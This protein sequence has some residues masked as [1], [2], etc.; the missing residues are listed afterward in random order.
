MILWTYSRWLPRNALADA[1]FGLSSR[2][3]QRPTGFI[4]KHAA[5]SPLSS[6][7]RAELSGLKEMTYLWE[8]ASLAQD[9]RQLQALRDTSGTV[10]RGSCRDVAQL[11]RNRAG[12]LC[13]SVRKKCEAVDHLCMEHAGEQATKRHQSRHATSI[14]SV[15]DA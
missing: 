8:N 2:L 12:A 11:R 15:F 14:H 5:R 7:F 3:A 6:G 10:T 1:F 4:P 9:E 13:S